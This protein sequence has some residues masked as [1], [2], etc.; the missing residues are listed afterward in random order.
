MIQEFGPYPIN[1]KAK[2]DVNEYLIKQLGDMNEITYFEL[3]RPEE[4]ANSIPM[5][6]VQDKPF[7]AR[8][9]NNKRRR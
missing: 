1:E 8:Y 2:W 5:A 4:L 6:K 3:T 7:Y 9:L